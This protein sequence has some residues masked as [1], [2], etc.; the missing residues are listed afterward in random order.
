MTTIKEFMDWCRANPKATISAQPIEIW[1][2]MDNWRIAISENTSINCTFMSGK[3]ILNVIKK[4][5]D[6]FGPDIYDDLQRTF[7]DL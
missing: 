7:N 3:Q 4:A 1:E 6:F 5:E 2:Q